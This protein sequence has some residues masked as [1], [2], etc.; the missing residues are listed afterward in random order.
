MAERLLCVSR[1]IWEELLDT[2]EGLWRGGGDADVP[3]IPDL[4]DL[5]EE[6]SNEQGEP[7]GCLEISQRRHPWWERE[8][9]EG[10]WDEARGWGDLDRIGQ[11][12]L[13]KLTGR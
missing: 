7:G 6:E 1:S 12:E 10:I 13:R 5:L 2:V 4:E 9:W 8:H 11:R 3:E